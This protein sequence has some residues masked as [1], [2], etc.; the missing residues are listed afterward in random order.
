MKKIILFISLILFIR[1]VNAETFYGDY[2]KVEK[3]YNEPLDE[4]K[5]EE[6][7]LYNT[8]KLNYKDLGYKEENNEFIKDENDFIEVETE[9]NN[10]ENS[11]EYINVKT[12]LNTKNTFLIN[13][14]SNNLTIKE[15]EIYYKDELINYSFSNEEEFLSLNPT[16]IN[17]YD[18]DLETFFNTPRRYINLA[19]KLN[20]TYVLNQLKIIIYSTSNEESTF[21]FKFNE[22][23][24]IKLNKGNKHIITFTNDESIEE[25]T[26]TYKE[27]KKL[28]KYY[29]EEKVHQNIY[30]KEGE[31]LL[32]D[33]YIINT[34]YYKRDK[35]IL[36]NTLII[37]DKNQDINSFIEYSSG[38]TII[39]H[40]VDYTKNGIYKCEFILNDIKVVKD[41]VVDIVGKTKEDIKPN[42]FKERINNKVATNIKLNK[43]NNKV[44]NKTLTIT[45]KVEEKNKTTKAITT[46]STNTK[47]PSKEEKSLNKFFIKIITIIFFIVLEIIIIYKKKKR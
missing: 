20:N 43:T 35:L 1:N 30:I 41:I 34:D 10:K 31:S 37:N 29:K 4:I 23:I 33:D 5:I 39:N 16:A 17:I 28:Y 36:S 44:K 8:Y 25:T 27:Y 13:N 14:I 26:Y 3:I 7:K 18:K 47:I 12:S 32:L 9:T 15:I 45:T 22:Y 6:Y 19:L 21:E 42:E 40:N 2:Y 38:K 24:P 46:T 11:I